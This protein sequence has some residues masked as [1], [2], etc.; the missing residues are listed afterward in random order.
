MMT[1]QTL[2]SNWCL[3]CEKKKAKCATLRK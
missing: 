2:I 1:A 3:G